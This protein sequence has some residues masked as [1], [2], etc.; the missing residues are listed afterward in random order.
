MKDNMIKNEIIKEDTSKFSEKTIAFS[1]NDSRLLFHT[2]KSLKR[3]IISHYKINKYAF[4]FYYIFSSVINILLIEF[5][6]FLLPKKV[7]CIITYDNFIKINLVENGMQQIFSDLYDINLFYPFRIYVNEKVQILRE[8]RKIFIGSK[9]DTITI[10]WKDGL[11]NLAYMF[12]NIQ[13]IK[14]ITINNLFNL[15]A[16]TSHMFYNCQKLES[17]NYNGTGNNQIIDATKMFY[18]CYSLTS[19]SF[20]GN[21][22]ANNINMQYMFYNCYNLNLFSFSSQMSVNDMKGML[23]N[24]YSIESVNLSNFNSSYYSKVNVSYLFYNCYNLRS[25]IMNSN[26]I[27]IEDMRFMFYNC[28]LHLNSLNLNNFIIDLPTNMSYLFYNCTK[29]NSITWESQVSDTKKS[30]DMRNMFFNCFE[31]KS[32]TV[33]FDNVQEPIN[34]ARMFYNCSKLENITIDTSITSSSYF[35]NDIHEMFYNCKKLSNLNFIKH[36]KTDST[37]DMSLLFYNCSS[38]RELELNFSNILTTNMKGMFQNSGLET[39]DLSQFYTKNVEIMWNMFKGC[40]SLITLNLNSFNTSKVTDMESMFEGCEKLQVLSLE[41]FDTS[42]VQYMNKMF[43]DCKGLTSLNFGNIKADSVGTMHQMFYNCQNLKYL[44]ISSLKEKGQS[45]AE[46][47]TGVAISN[48]NQ[49]FKFCIE[50]DENIPN[51]FK[52]LFNITN[53]ERDCSEICYG[54]ERVNISEKKLCCKYVKYEDNCYKK[55][56]SKTQVKNIPN[57]CEVFICTE[58]DEY[59]DYEQNECIKNISGYY[60]NDTISKTID[61]C[62]EDCIECKGGW[63][64][65]TTNCTICKSEKPFI[66]KGNCHPNCTPGFYDERNTICKC[67][68]KKCNLCSEKSLEFDLCET[69]N[70]N[71]YP[72]END[73]TNN[74]NY[75][76]F[77]NCYNN[78]EG[79]YLF[80]NQTYKPCYNSCRYCTKEGNFENHYCTSCN[81]ANIF[82]IQTDDSEKNIYNC[83]P[84]CTYYYYFDEKGDYHCTKE[85]KCPDLYNKLVDGDRRCVND[86][87]I[88]KKKKYEFKSICYEVCPPDKS[89]NES[90]SDYF[91]KITC[92]FE[93]PFEMVKE[94]ICVSNC[95]IMERYYGLCRTNYRGNRSNDEVQDKVLANLQDDIIENFDYHFINDTFSIVLE[96]IGNTYEI[97]TTTKKT[98]D[99]RKVIFISIIID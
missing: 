57:I 70:K 9:D 16:N 31:L 63:S 85:P 14:K 10:V 96:E 62:H 53:S 79:Y 87:S 36:I 92:P 81:D 41:N 60:I 13:S 50:E 6:L 56:P 23:Y 25:L 5:I 75:P 47:F 78:P 90:I 58:S 61:K 44:N 67:F 65:E 51:I 66:Y 95:T 22:T 19:V 88:M 93:A 12:A 49:V 27:N 39:L 54:L 84:N 42:K 45:F 69:C 52:L 34:M 11:S 74:P 26:Y 32:F 99:P 40:K 64:N 46:I 24:C 77:K 18:N 59:Y 33:P 3:R 91:C 30:N 38:L 4:N 83:Y 73:I 89:F 20:G 8:T 68:D 21:Y 80:N 71:Y 98:E 94:Q 97:V 15:E 7:L 72:K 86:C 37:V 28:S 35:P 29:L 2:S 43:R 1:A 17:F 76:D 55:C 48:V 82:G